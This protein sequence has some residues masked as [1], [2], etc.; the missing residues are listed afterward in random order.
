MK[1]R[2]LKAVDVLLAN[3][4]MRSFWFFL[5]LLTV[6]TALVVLMQMS[7]AF[8]ARQLVLVLDP[9]GNYVIGEI[10]DLEDAQTVHTA[11]TSL[12]MEALFDR[13]PAGLDHEDRLRA[14][15]SEAARKQALEHANAQSEEFSAHQLHQKVEISTIELLNQHDKTIKIRAEGQLVHAGHIRDR[16]FTNTMPVAVE[17]Q[18]VFN[19]NILTN[20]R[21][22]SIVRDYTIITP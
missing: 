9:L 22:P 20:G 15:F 13:D 10:Q 16:P 21:Y 8:N 5:W 18:F 17:F 2:P 4:W 7:K 3:R 11:Q 14:L 1:N 6:V 19:T 12:A